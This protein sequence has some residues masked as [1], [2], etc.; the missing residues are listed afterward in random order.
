M[1]LRILKN[2]LRLRLN[3]SDIEQ[4]ERHQRISE[5][6]YFPN[7]QV[8]R[9]SLTVS[10]ALSA[11]CLENEIGVAITKDACDCLVNLEEGL[12]FQ[13][14]GD[15]VDALRILIEKDMPCR[16]DSHAASL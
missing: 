6:V 15:G 5:S 2:S 8:F 4:L 16:K 10:G 1:K 13:I 11:F 7:S 9:Y 14:K 12:D 3:H